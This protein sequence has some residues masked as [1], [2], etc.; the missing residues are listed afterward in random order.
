MTRTNYTDYYTTEEWE[1]FTKGQR[2]YRSTK[3]LMTTSAY[4]Y[5]AS[6]SREVTWSH[7]D[8]I[9]DAITYTMRDDYGYDYDREQGYRELF[10]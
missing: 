5:A 3:H 2:H 7:T 9:I 1:S 6:G 10:A 8:S 4:N